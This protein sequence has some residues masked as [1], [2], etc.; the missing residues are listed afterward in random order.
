M[1]R[2]PIIVAHRGLHATVPENSLAAFKA[3]WAAGVA[4]AECDVRESA[5]GPLFVIHDP[6]LDRT[7]DGRGR[8]DGRLDA[9]LD[10]CR[11]R[12]ADRRVTRHPLPRLADVVRAMPPAGRLLVEVK[13]V[14]DAAGL[15]RDC[16]G[17]D[18][19]V[20]S[21]ASDDLEAVHELDPLVPLAHLVETATDLEAALGMRYE[22]VHLEHN[23]LDPAMAAR[24]RRAGK[25]V[26][27]W[28]VNAE[29][30]LRR[31]V[32]LGVDVV[33]TDHPQLAMRVVDDLCDA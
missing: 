32:G 25:S 14:A 15:L 1:L 8:V 11:L 9:E 6:T 19:W 28:T 13:A 17:R 10:R 33:I 23:L 4:W 12:D 16:R 30:D 27:V 5:T 21:F 7:T 31:V 24:L 20:Q 3:G 2:R 18:V 29:A 22:S 26:G